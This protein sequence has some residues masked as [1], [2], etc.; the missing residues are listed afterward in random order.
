MT[1]RAR[2]V[3]QE[4]GTVLVVA[5]DPELRVAVRGFV[6][7]L[8]HEVEELV[9]AVHRVDP[10]GIG[11][12][13][14]EHAP[15]LVPGEDA[16]PLAVLEA[17]LRTVVEDGRVA[18]H[19]LGRER[20]AEVVVEVRL[21]G[22]DPGEGPAHPLPVGGDLPDGGTGDR[23]EGGVA[24]ARV[25][26]RAAEAGGQAGTPEPTRSAAVTGQFIELDRPRRL[27]FSWSCSDWADPSVRSEV[28]VSLEDHGAD[29]TMMTIEHEQLPPGQVMPHELGWAAVAVQLAEA[30]GG[31][32]A[33][34]RRVRYQRPTGSGA[35]P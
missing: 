13:R 32:G 2:A 34:A 7:A 23:G 28:T 27:R 17:G 5:A 22:R 19:L 30:L 1:A 18:G 24:G 3:H 29:E 9:G 25:A 21:A 16:D 14:V 31:A 35:G 20:G 12:V 4:S 11:G 6:A 10:P 8:G 33:R 15:R 26:G